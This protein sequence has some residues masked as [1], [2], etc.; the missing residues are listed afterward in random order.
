MFTVTMGRTLSALSVIAT[1]A[2]APNTAA[3]QIIV[4]T[5]GS[6]VVGA[7]VNTIVRRSVQVSDDSVRSYLTRFE[8][9]VLDDDSGDAT[10]VTMVLDNDGTFIR[11]S[12][13]HAKIIEAVPGR[14]VTV[15]G[16]SVGAIEGR[17][18][19]INGDSAKAITI[20]GSG[21]GGAIT[22]VGSV[23]AVNTLRR[24]DAAASPLG[25]GG[26]SPGEIGGV[27]TKR[28]AAGEMGKGPVI[29]TFI[30]LK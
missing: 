22:T 17:V 30:Y 27:A 8:P 7:N 14:I 28:Y 11:S 16:D 21:D 25:L 19:S 6:G 26:V 29:V 20:T 1:V 13:R 12:S 2:L 10:V 23:I 9:S 15:N 18:I 4:R 3:A 24:A 5:D